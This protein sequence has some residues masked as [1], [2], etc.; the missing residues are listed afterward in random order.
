ME[1]IIKKLTAF[2]NKTMW[3]TRAEK[4]PVPKAVL[5]GVLK[6]IVLSARGFAT[7]RGALRA[8]A[9]TF[10]TLLSIVP[11]AAMAF[12]IAKGF[13]FDKR[14]QQ[15]LLEKFAGQEEVIHNIIN[16]AQ[17]MLENTKGGM[18]AGIGVVVLFWTVIRVLSHIESA[19]NNI[20]GVQ[21]RAAVRKLG[22][23]LAIMLICPVLMIMS[24]SV[25]VFITSQVTAISGKLGLLDMVGPVIFLGLK[26]LPYS[27]IWILFTMVYLI[28]PNTR[29]RFSSAFLAGVVAGTA[30]QFAQAAYISFQILVAKY[31]AIYGSF[32][33]LPLF[34]IWLQVSWLIVLAGAE[35]SYAGQNLNTLR[36]QTGKDRISLSFYRLILLQVCH[37]IVTV[38]KDAKPA[39]TA[40]E[41]S[42]S[43]NLPVHLV[44]K[45]SE[46]LVSGNILTRVKLGK[47][48]KNGQ[49]AFQPARDINDLTVQMVLSAFEDI[50]NGLQLSQNHEKLAPFSKTLDIFRREIEQSASNRLIKDI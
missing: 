50:G 24:G 46:D 38:F 8:S 21:S 15:E 34:L 40:D 14:L 35:I 12:G 49:A 23:Y 2:L 10:Y 39:Q 3:E 26:F 7:H 29:V 9:L 36:F 17:T 41:I 43:L 30:Y 42:K 28:M 37:H 18:I 16:F 32:A 6:T 19:F 45:A 27:L 1:E 13:G 48:E 33:A 25:T 20:W 44:E 22:D 31:N 47:T 4:L 11:V 5:V